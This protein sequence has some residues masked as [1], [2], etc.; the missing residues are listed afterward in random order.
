MWKPGKTSSLCS[1]HFNDED[2]TRLM[3][4]GLNLKRELKQDDI[5]FCVYPSKHAKRKEDEDQEPPSKRSRQ[6][7]MVR[8]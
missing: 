1:M 7:R 2:F 6:K 5:G 4:S 3:N 8:F